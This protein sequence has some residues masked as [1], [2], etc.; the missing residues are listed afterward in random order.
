MNKIVVQKFGGTTV[1]TPDKI[2]LVAMEI[3]DMVQKGYRVAA[4]LSAMGQQTDELISLAKSVTDDPDPRELD[5][6]VTVGERISISLLS[7]AL[8]KLGKDAISFTG[9]QAGIIT[10]CNH[11]DARIL[12]IT[13]N[14][15]LEALNSD[16]IAI[17]AGYQGVS[18]KKEIT[19]L[20]RGGS[21]TS[22]VAI[23]CVLRAHYCDIFTDVDGVFATDPRVLPRAKHI[24]RIG[25]EEMMELAALG[26]NVVHPRAV[27]IAQ[28]YG[29]E[30]RVKNIENYFKK[31]GGKLTEIKNFPLSLESVTVKGLASDN[32]VSLISADIDDENHMSFLASLSENNVPVIN[33]ILNDSGKSRSLEILVRS[34]NTDK[35][36]K[37]LEGLKCRKIEISRDYAL[38]SLVGTGSGN[39]PELMKKLIGVLKKNGSL[40]K[41][42]SCSEV[43]ISFLTEKK[44]SPS[45]LNEIALVFDL[46]EEE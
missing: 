28:R 31:C 22:A 29:L 4:V 21:D 20:G 14:R 26:A 17:I 30:L 45:L 1:G 5:M 15:V 25:Y 44:F 13:P 35:A 43:K 7:M 8:K 37:L 38:I 27:E 39:S 3:S 24:E 19:T 34:N 41:M 18:E 11:N 33:F 2:N 10:D 16:K 36:R 23:A 6:L 12:R 40:V 42:I 32:E 46:L 9:S